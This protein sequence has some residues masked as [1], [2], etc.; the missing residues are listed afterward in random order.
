MNATSAHKIDSAAAPRGEHGQIVLARGQ[1]IAMRAWQNEAPGEPKAPTTRAYDT[2]G[3]VLAGRAELHCGGEIL[4]L[5]AGD[6]Y[7]VPRG[8]SHTYKIL[9]SFSAV[10]ATNPPA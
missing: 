6:S 9:E 3:Y 10:E 8:I 1:S 4:S 5:A 7:L 2:V